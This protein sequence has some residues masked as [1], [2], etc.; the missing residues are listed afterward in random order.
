MIVN[1]EDCLEHLAGMRESLATFTIEKTDYTIMNSVAR[2]VFKGTALTDRQF[3]LMREKLVNYKQQFV[4]A[5]VDNFDEVIIQTRQPIR[6]IDRSKYIR[7]EDNNIVVRF[8]FKKTDIILIQEIISNDGYS[9]T[10]GSHQH[11]FDYTEVNVLNILDRFSK[12]D[13]IIDDELTEVYNKIKSIKDNPQEYLSG[14][15]NTQLI[16]INPTLSSV[17]ETEL[18]DLSNETFVQFI[19]RKFRYG[20]D[21]IEELPSTSLAQKIATRKEIDYL[22]KPSQESTSDILTALWELNRF[23]MLVI[24]SAEHAE[25]QLYEFANHYRD[26]LN[27][28]QQSVLFRLEEADAGFNQLVKDRKLNNWVDK[29]TKV[30][31]I[32]KSKLP[33]LLV[34]NEWKPGIAFSY[35]SYIDKF[36]DSYVKFNC[37]LI[38]YREETMSAFKKYSR[39]H[40]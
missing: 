16:N 38:V 7:L 8:P 12:K 36:V 22:S 29:N 14:I 32:N 19:D 2:Q 37:D 9:H 24:L 10:K 1:I 35:D 34:N 5:G 11:V 28:E 25:Q 40:G 15:A 6:Q 31:Y 30:V 33:K 18:G 21:Y 17:I 26:I 23:P 20:F 4:E 27:S 39:F 13:F 3:A